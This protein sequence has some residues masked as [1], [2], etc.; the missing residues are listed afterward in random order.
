MLIIP[1]LN[2]Y[3]DCYFFSLD[4]T[5]LS[6]CGIDMASEAIQLVN[7]AADLATDSKAFFNDGQGSSHHPIFCTG[8]TVCEEVEESLH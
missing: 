8:L 6:K 1:S 5:L 7:T 4:S 2:C 3:Q